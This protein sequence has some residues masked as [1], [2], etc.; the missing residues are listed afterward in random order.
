MVTPS[1]S[2]LLEHSE[3]RSRTKNSYY[4]G[5]KIKFKGGN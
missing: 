2:F 5:K 4:Y 3:N 1:F